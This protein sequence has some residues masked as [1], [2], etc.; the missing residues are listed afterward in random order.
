MT[1]IEV[2]SRGTPRG[3]IH[4]VSLADE[5]GPIGGFTEFHGNFPLM[6]G[7]VLM[8]H[9]DIAVSNG[10]S[11]EIID[12]CRKIGAAGAELLGDIFVKKLKADNIIDYKVS[13]TNSF[14]IP[15]DMR[16]DENDFEK[17]LLDDL[18]KKVV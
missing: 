10:V 15:A 3:S 17:T 9:K 16:L 1:T 12:C 11:E 7:L 14:E 4:K 8:K 18:M 13:G 2:E 6:V 5:K